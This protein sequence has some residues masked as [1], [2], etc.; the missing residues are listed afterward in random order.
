M[1]YKIFPFLAWFKGYNL[2]LFKLDFVAGITVAL[3]L[4]PPSM[5]YAQLADCLPITDCTP[6]FCRP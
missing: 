5:A 1:I 4:I 2:G 3:V 6:P